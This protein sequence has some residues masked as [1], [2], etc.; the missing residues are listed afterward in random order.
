[1]SEWQ[2]PGE[3]PALRE[4]DVHIWRAHLVAD[5]LHIAHDARFLAADES[6]RAARF[7]FARDRR[8]FIVTRSVLRR[9]LGSYLDVAP[10]D[11]R[12]DYAPNG[13]PV[14]APPQDASGIT[15][16]VSHARDWALM[17]FVRGRRVGIDLEFVR[18]LDDMHQVA[19]HVFSSREMAAFRGLPPEQQ[20]AAFYAGWT[21]KEAFIKAVGAGMSYP[22]QQFDVTLAPHEP[23][24]LLRIHDDPDGARRWQMV[25]LTPA[26]GF[27]GALVVEGAATSIAYWEFRP[28]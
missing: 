13:K 6:E 2:T 12:V 5:E 8:R 3:V 9:L 19:A 26:P 11:I 14:L 20:P 28:R 21:R 18:P 22:L 24:R 17:A 27:A 23:A 25:A 1:M 7:V 16:N 10:A 15:F 4:D